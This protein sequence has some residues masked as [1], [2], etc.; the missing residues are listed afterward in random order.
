VL[1]REGKSYE[2][3]RE[4]ILQKLDIENKVV[5]DLGCGTGF[6][7]LG[8]AGFKNIAIEDANL[9]AKG[10]SSKGEY[11]ETGIFIATADKF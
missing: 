9:K 1:D 6:I 11:I 4:R 8:L 5:G 10:Y 7:T 3:R 2:R